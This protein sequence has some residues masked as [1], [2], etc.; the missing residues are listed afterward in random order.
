MG[1][2]LRRMDE[3]QCGHEAGIWN[4]SLF[5]KRRTDGSFLLLMAKVTDDLLMVGARKDLESF[6][7]VL[8]QRFS[9]SETII[10]ERI[11]FNVCSVE[12]E[13]NQSEDAETG[14]EFNA[15]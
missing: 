1:D 11:K 15:F 9:I 5:V 6:V 8:G 13:M 3:K 12:Q 14:D 7:A 10:D 4:R 2:C